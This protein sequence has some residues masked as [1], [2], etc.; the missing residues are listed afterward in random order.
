MTDR[1]LIRG[2]DW[3]VAWDA[4]HRGHKYVIG[5]DVVFEGNTLIHVGH[6]YTGDAEHVID[7]SGLLVMPG[8][9]NAHAHTHRDIHAKGF[10]EDLATHQ[11][12]MTQ[13]LEYTFVLKGDA[14]SCAA[15]FDASVCSLLRSGCTTLVELFGYK[16]RPFDDWVGQV[17]ATG[18]RASL[19]PMVASGYW[20]T[21]SGRDHHYAWHAGEGVDDLEGALELIDA[22]LTHPSGRLSG[23]V[24]AAQADTCTERL[25]RLCKAAADERGIP[26]QTH[27]A[28][29]VMEFRE[30]IRRH[31]MTPVEWLESIGLLGPNVL[32]GH[33]IHIDQ[34]PWVAYFEH[35]DLERLARSGVTV[36]NCAR[37]FAQWG[38]MLRSLGS[39]RAAG[40]NMALGTDG[41]PH[42]MIEEMRIAGLVSKV[43]SGHVDLLRAEDVF[44]TAT[45]GAARALGRD[46]VGR[47]AP[48][49]KA[50]VVLVDLS[51]PSMRPVRDPLRSLV[52]SG[53]AT[54]VRDV[55]VDGVQVV[56][57]GRVLTIDED[58]ALDRLQAGQGR[59]MARVPD[60]DWA[61]RSADA[62]SPLCLPVEGPDCSGS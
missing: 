49:A 12:W 35:K 16:H 44:E 8:M 6:A 19:C 55:Y 9:I 37:A 59:A 7:G 36:V 15:A 47:L 2:A 52:Y 27:A 50:D 25:F 46:D 22:A 56:D 42:D 4:K 17:A 54:A 53:V 61:G 40:I 3:I 23:M 5:G 31:G 39:Y 45:L 43:A 28:Q 32:L 21:T 34:H 20:Y 10:F 51:H 30:M 58:A 38:D 1:T 41:Y 26:L 60:M 13:L 29:S 57:R 62:I 33:A 14:E 11:M 24:G 48:G 18:I